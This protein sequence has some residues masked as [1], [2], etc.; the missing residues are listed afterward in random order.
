MPESKFIKLKT[1]FVSVDPDRDDYEKIK[2]FLS[3][4]DA[5]IIGLTSTSNDD[6][7]LKD[8]LRKFRIYSTK[9][10]YDMMDEEEKK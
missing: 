9:I 6:P 5:D 2:K 3:I 7:D 8:M 1:V 4:F 10:E